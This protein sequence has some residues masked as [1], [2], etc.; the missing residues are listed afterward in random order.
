M[1]DVYHP[2]FQKYGVDLVITTHNHNYQRTYPL[3][4]IGNGDSEPAI[5]DRNNSTYVNPH[6]PIFIT[7]GTAGEE[8]HDLD[9]R[10][11]FVANQFKCNGFFKYSY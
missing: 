9:G 3:K 10:Y 6:G 11:P 8:L 2:I 7:V 4:L 5:A 1:K